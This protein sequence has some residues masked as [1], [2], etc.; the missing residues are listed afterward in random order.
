MTT[1]D[2]AALVGRASAGDEVAFELLVRRH[3]DAV[4]RLAMGM[5]RDRG[6]AE[7]A[8]QE[9][10]IKAHRALGGF[11]ADASFKTWLLAIAHRTCLDQIKRPKPEIASLDKA[12][13]Q[14]ARTADQ[15]TRVALEL[16]VA[17]LPDDERQAFMLVDALGLSREEAAQMV[18]V[19]VTTLKSRLAR[20]H[21]K[22]VEELSGTSKPRARKAAAGGAQKTA[23]PTKGTKSTKGER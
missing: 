22:L 16:A 1:T 14:R 6:A 8:T 18:E 7:D 21:T 23:R 9:T 20:A 15:A 10:F 3:T 2:D 17:K 4:W 13:E 11:R 5:L 19:P 12:R